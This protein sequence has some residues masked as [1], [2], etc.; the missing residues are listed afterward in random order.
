[1]PGRTGSPTWTRSRPASNGSAR[2]SRSWSTRGLGGS[3]VATV[4]LWPCK[5]FGWPEC[6]VVEVELGQLEATALGIALNRTAELAEWDEAALASLLTEL[7]AEDALAGVG[8]T[9]EDID[10]VFAELQAEVD[11]GELDDPGPGGPRKNPSAARA[12]SGSSETTASCA[13]TRPVVK[14]WLGSWRARLPCFSPPIR[15]TSWTTR[16]R[17][18]MASRATTRGWRSTAVSWRSAWPTAERTQRSTSG[19]RTAG[20][21]SYNGHGR[22]LG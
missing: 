8:Y 20:R 11:P 15:P 10:A 14:T 9:D 6:D 1:M 12:I 17:G 5:K 19:T 3:S 21:R 13:G 7:R 18:G 16:A 22:R 4:G 2:R